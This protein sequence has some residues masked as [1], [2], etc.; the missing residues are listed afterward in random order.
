MH[1]HQVVMQNV[2]VSSSVSQILLA[3]IG[4]HSFV[5]QV[6]LMLQRVVKSHVLVDHRATVLLDRHASHQHLVT[7][8]IPFSA[9]KLL[10]MLLLHAPSP[11]HR[12]KVLN[13]LTAKVVFPTRFVMKTEQTHLR[14]L[15]STQFLQRRQTLIIVETISM[16]LPPAVPTPVQV[17]CLKNALEIFYVLQAHHAKLRDLS[18]VEQVGKKQHLHVPCHVKAVQALIVP[19]GNN[20]SATLHA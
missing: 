10:K 6:G 13:V 15:H 1:A 4:D 20:V 14:H 3:K 12:V 11:V 16:M 5:D 8:A 2:R 7:R 9:V 17:V 19:L 18:S